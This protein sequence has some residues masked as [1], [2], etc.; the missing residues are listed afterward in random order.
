[1]AKT[2][3]PNVNNGIGRSQNKAVSLAGKIAASAN[4]V[5]L[6]CRVNSDPDKIAVLKN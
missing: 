2:Q 6:G 5:G 1:M 3:G 4:I